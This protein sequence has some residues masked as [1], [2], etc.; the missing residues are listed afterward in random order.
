MSG[1]SFPHSVQEECV[2]SQSEQE[3]LLSD[4]AAGVREEALLRTSYHQTPDDLLD[5]G[6]SQVSSDALYA[7]DGQSVV[8]KDESKRHCTS[9]ENEGEEGAERDEKNEGRVKLPEEASAVCWHCRGDGKAGLEEF[10]EFLR[11]TPAEH[12]LELWMDIERLKTTCRDRKE[13]QT[14]LFSDFTLHL[15]ASFVSDLHS[16]L[17][18]IY[19]MKA[20][21]SNALFQ[22][23]GPDEKPVLAL[24]QSHRSEGGAA[25]QTRAVYLPLLDRGET[26]RS[27]VQPDR[28]S[29]LLLVLKEACLCKCI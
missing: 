27:T 28:V 10:K 21:L 8:N 6:G 19:K 13:R 16:Q 26:T 20:S 2:G 14:L 22:V 24:Q 12:L 5:G 1:C 17:E 29:V 3:R 15:K 18:T 9:T 4:L 7:M 23:S 25:L 11:G